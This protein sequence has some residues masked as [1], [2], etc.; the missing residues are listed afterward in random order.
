MKTGFRRTPGLG[1]TGPSSAEKALRALTLGADRERA[2]R[3]VASHP[4]PSAN[5]AATRA[6][7]GRNCARLSRLRRAR[8][9]FLLVG[10]PKSRLF[11][12]KIG[13]PSEE[14][15]AASGPEP[16]HKETSP[17]FLM[18]PMRPASRSGQEPRLL[19]VPALS[20]GSPF[21][22]PL[23][24]NHFNG[25]TPADVTP[26]RGKTVLSDAIGREK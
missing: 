19:A 1:R 23:S 24:F 7:N 22:S 6:K 9:P 11:G 15:Q 14:S 20:R 17:P 10:L 18:G 3:C 2:L 16:D 12:E 8:R 5:S 25:L 13:R 21:A 4:Y 26:Q